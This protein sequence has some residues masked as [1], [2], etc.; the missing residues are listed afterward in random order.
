ME[1][2]IPSAELDDW[3]GELKPYQQNTMKQLL[4]SSSGPEEAA[5][6]WVT[7]CGAESV[8]P[9]GGDRDTR[10]FWEHLKHEF[11]KFL[12][13][14]NAYA[15]E[16]RALFAEGPVARA[17]LISVLSAAIGATI[18]YAATLLAPP[19]AILLWTVC[20]IG[21]NAYCSGG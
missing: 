9:F 8:I 15:E 20:R 21:R 3:L 1:F 16:K 11:R 19:V 7:A 14:D 13:D 6:K 12:C 5:E 4:S 18:G 2:E 10:P 17:V